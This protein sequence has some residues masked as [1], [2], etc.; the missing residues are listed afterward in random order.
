MNPAMFDSIRQGLGNNIRE[1]AM[2]AR[3]LPQQRRD[4]ARRYV[5]AALHWCTK[6]ATQCGSLWAPACSR[7]LLTCRSSVTSPCAMH[8]RSAPPTLPPAP[9]LPFLGQPFHWRRVPSLIPVAAAS[10][11]D[12]KTVI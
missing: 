6:S 10:E 8:S 2:G 4:D 5:Y 1:G 12:E 11:N 3:V 9:Y 7:C